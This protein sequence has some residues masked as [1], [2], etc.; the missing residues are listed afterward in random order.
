MC[1]AFTTKNAPV[2]VNG[3][4]PS[5]L[6]VTAAAKW[7]Q[8]RRFQQHNFPHHH[9]PP[10]RSYTTIDVCSLVPW[11]LYFSVREQA[12]SEAPALQ[13]ELDRLESSLRCA[14]AKLLLGDTLRCA[15]AKLL[16]GDKLD[17]ARAAPRTSSKKLYKLRD[18]P[19]TL[20]TA[21]PP[22]VS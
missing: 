20:S 12:R 15:D 7:L 4:T 2:V 8:P 11:D 16:L 9:N 14:D 3:C 21:L 10:G 17:A 18:F 22:G 1:S 5:C 6:A 13:G 19:H